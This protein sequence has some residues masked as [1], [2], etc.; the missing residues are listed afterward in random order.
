LGFWDFFGIF[1][2][3]RDYFGIFLGFK[4]QKI[5]LFPLAR[6]SEPIINNV[7]DPPSNTTGLNLYSF[8]INHTHFRLELSIDDLEDKSQTRG[9]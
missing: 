7:N 9:N 2:G 6:V 8:G 1:S 4:I 5:R 3:F